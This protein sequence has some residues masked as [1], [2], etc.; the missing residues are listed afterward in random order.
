MGP[1]FW[2]THMGQRFFEHTLPDLAR[3]IQ[4]LAEAIEALVAQRARKELS[5]P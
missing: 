1:H 5:K 4:R 2:Q 3:Q